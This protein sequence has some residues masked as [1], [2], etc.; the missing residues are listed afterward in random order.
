MSKYQ[1]GD[2]IAGYCDYPVNQNV[3]GIVSS[4][5]HCHPG[6]LYL[7]KP[8]VPVP[9]YE[10]ESDG[11][12]PISEDLVDYWKP[13]NKLNASKEEVRTTLEDIYKQ[14][15]FL[16]MRMPG[17]DKDNTP[18]HYIGGILCD[19]DYVQGELLRS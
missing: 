19:I 10:E 4:I 9:G 11:V 12:F 13:A 15:S 18:A 7:V 5:E 17:I 3:M 1:K 2:F 14:L 16:R 8:V 6:P